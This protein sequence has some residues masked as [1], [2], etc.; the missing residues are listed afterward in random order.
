MAVNMNWAVDGGS[1]S[2]KPV[3]AIRPAVDEPRTELVR[4]PRTTPKK[5]LLSKKKDGTQKYMFELKHPEDWEIITDKTMCQLFSEVFQEGDKS[6]IEPFF[7]SY[8][9]DRE[10]HILLA[11]EHNVSLIECDISLTARARTAHEPQIPKEETTDTTDAFFIWAGNPLS[12][13]RVKLASEKISMNRTAVKEALERSE[14]SGW[15]DELAQEALAFIDSEDIAKQ[16]GEDL[17]MPVFIVTAYAAA[18]DPQCTTRDNFDR[19]CG[20]AARFRRGKKGVGSVISSNL[21][22]FNDN[23]KNKKA[24]RYI[25]RLVQGKMA[26]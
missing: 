23:P 15:T 6:R 10:K 24:A 2:D 22:H 20:L 3:V 18:K 17:A 8:Y 1:K 7:G 9:K 21:S 14:E 13:G 16:F 5:R 4:V 25:Y 26:A 12:F 11:R 19:F